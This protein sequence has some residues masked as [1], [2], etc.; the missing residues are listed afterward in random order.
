MNLTPTT[1]LLE[2]STGSRLYG[3]AT[4][5]SDHDKWVVV[6]G[7]AAPGRRSAETTTSRPWTWPPSRRW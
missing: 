7:P 1:V 6:L 3:T 2:T 4:P 5:D